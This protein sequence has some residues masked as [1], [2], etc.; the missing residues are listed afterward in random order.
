MKPPSCSGCPLEKAPGPIWGKG[1][2]HPKLVILGQNPGPQEIDEGEPFVGSSGDVL[3]RALR[4]TD[5]LQSDVL[6]TNVVKCFVKPG[7][8]IPYGAVQHCRPLLEKELRGT[9]PKSYLCVGQESFNEFARPKTLAL[10]H[11]R[12]TMERDPNAWLR[13]C[14]Y[15][16]S[17]DLTDATSPVI[18]G[19]FHPSFVMRTGFMVSPVFDADVAKAVRFALGEAH[20][21][22]V[23]YNYNPSNQEVV[24]YAEEC[25]HSNAFGLDIETPE[26][27]PDDEM[28]EVVETP[29]E[30]IGLSARVG[31]AIG[32]AQDQIEL[33]KPLLDE[34][35]EARPRA[36]AYNGGFD[37]FHLGKKYNFRG[38]EKCDAML[39]FHI[40]WSHARR[41]DLATMCS[42][43]T[44]VPYHK[45]LRKRQ[46]DLYNT[47]DTFGV[48]EGGENL[49]KELSQTH[50]SIAGTQVSQIEV[51]RTL[52]RLI[53]VTCDWRTKG[54][55]YDTELS[56]RYFAAFQMGLEKYEEWWNQNIPMFSWRSPKQLI[57][58]FKAMG[59]KVP[60]IQR[61]KKTKEGLKERSRSE[62]VNEEFLETLEEK[63]NQT[64]TLIL[65]MRRLAKASDQVELQASDDRLH[66]RAKMHGQVGGRI[67]CVR[68]N[69]QQISEDLMGVNPRECISPEHSDDCIISADY[70]QVEF[71]FYAWYAKCQKLMDIKESGTYVYGY[72][73]QD[74]W[75]E[76][77]FKAGMPPTKANKL[78][79]EPWKLLVAKSWP[80]G[81]TYGRG[82]PNPADQGLP[83]TIT[84]ARQI[85]E[86]YHSDYPE[87]GIYHRKVLY[88][89]ER[90]RILYTIF[91]RSRQFPN[92]KGQRNDIL[93]FPG[94]TSA[95]DLLIRN[96]ILPLDRAFKE[97]EWG[98]RSRLYFTVHDSVVMNCQG[99]GKDP[100]LAIEMADWVQ[101]T[102][103]API[104][105]MNG[106]W[107]PCEVKIGP[108]WGKGVELSKFKSKLN[109]FTL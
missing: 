4:K 57:E 61:V 51:F 2:S 23:R 94:Q 80:L 65:T 75:G 38:V 109:S 68:Q 43:Y 106:Y 108:N 58:M 86:K 3:R 12:D 15:P 8:S 24:E 59:V 19:T 77:F 11:N 64:A 78:D 40:R 104:S 44:N 84:R 55:P 35:R 83:I 67:Q 45:N 71:W 34:E 36:W 39:A 29:I 48:L 72:F 76:P 13:G 73:Y 30:V 18:I 52:N 14:P 7:T 5:I 50:T 100:R 70:S 101:A 95:V 21:S 90:N 1:S 93:S 85:Y 107:I 74:V 31:E 91:G 26:D 99:G 42:L 62:S 49:W 102:M 53:D 82:V 28:D 17:G 25:A 37:F 56:A 9:N 98:E 22:N 97:G 6:I 27:L 32:V 63:G 87:I 69:V 105:E 47:F 89:A 54:C 10:E 103:Q 41:K 66:T 88:E 33:L 79:V 60:T 20:L 96:A 92:P 81:F 46:D 16:L